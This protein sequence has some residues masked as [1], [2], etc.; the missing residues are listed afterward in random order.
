MSVYVCM[1]VCMC[2]CMYVC[3]CVCMYVGKSV[4]EALLCK[5]FTAVL[6]C[7][8]LYLMSKASRK[9]RIL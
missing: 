5:A 2:A 8:L 6:R 7:G 3:M 9:A 4:D 1:Y